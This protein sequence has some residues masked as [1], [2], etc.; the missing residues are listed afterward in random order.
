[1][2]PPLGTSDVRFQTFYEFFKSKFLTYF[3]VNSPYNLNILNAIVEKL[4][5][6]FTFYM[7]KINT[8]FFFFLIS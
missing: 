3:V 4:L 2:L 7:N 8:K 6:I 1:M 5:S